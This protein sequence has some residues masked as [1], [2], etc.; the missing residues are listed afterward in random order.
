MNVLKLMIQ[1]TPPPPNCLNVKRA[2]KVLEKS[3]PRR[4]LKLGNPP[5]PVAEF[6]YAPGDPRRDESP[7]AEAK[8]RAPLPPPPPT[9][10]EIFLEKYYK[11]HPECPRI[12]F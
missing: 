12:D 2:L 11:E 6:D 3:L 8:R 5:V 1:Q 7:E 10:V 4:E 9:D